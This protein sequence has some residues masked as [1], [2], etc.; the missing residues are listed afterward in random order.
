MKYRYSKYN[1]DTYV[2]GGRP[3]LSEQ[4]SPENDS[5]T[6][7]NDKEL[8]DWMRETGRRNYEKIG[9]AHV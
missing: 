7:L 4:F 6:Q 2:E 9:R 8:Q 5:E 1:K 3:H